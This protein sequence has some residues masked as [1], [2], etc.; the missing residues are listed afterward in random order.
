MSN[1]YPIYRQIYARKSADGSETNQG[2][3]IIR[4]LCHRFEN[5]ERNVTMDSFFSS[6]PLCELL[7]IWKLS[8]VGTLK[9]N[10]A[11]IPLELLQLNNRLP[12]S[13][14]FAFSQEY[15][16]RI[17]ANMFIYTKEKENCNIDLNNA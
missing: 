14:L 7:M 6:L 9:K 2:E 5:S 11:Y 12:L 15:C 8:M 13:S 3:R 16:S 4:D 10:K 1:S 17:L